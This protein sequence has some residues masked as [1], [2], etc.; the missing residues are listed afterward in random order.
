MSATGWKAQLRTNLNYNFN[1]ALQ[2]PPQVGREDQLGDLR[3][4]FDPTYGARTF[5]FVQL[6][7]SSANLTGTECV[8]FTDNSEFT[9]TTVVGGNATEPSR[10]RCAGA[11]QYAVQGTA[12]NSTNPVLNQ[13]NRGWIQ[14]EGYH[15]GVNT[16][17][18]SA[19]LGSLMEPDITSG[20][21]TFV[22]A[23]TAP[24]Y[25]TCGRALANTTSSLTPVQ[26]MVP[27]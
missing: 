21:F 4:D 15:P 23:G 14:V 25:V 5:R 9:V 22:A 20:N 24:P 12:G 16:G 17:T 6:A 18:T 1:Q 8:W 11:A 2:T 27:L 7:N 13:G 26:L 10:N 19:V 3:K